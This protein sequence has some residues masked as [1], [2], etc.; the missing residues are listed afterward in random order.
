[1]TK[2][3]KLEAPWSIEEG[4]ATFTIHTANRFLIAAVWHDEE[5]SREFNL[6]REEARRVAV[7]ISRLPDLLAIEKAL[8]ALEA[9]EP[10]ADDDLG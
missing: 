10:G 4:P 1:M 9:G 3:R 8:D 7:A 2:V 6:R 5:P